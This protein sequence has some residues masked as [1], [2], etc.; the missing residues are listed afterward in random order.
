V[1]TADMPGGGRSQYVSRDGSRF[2]VMAVAQA[3]RRNL[4]VAINAV[5]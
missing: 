3:S 4:R 1:V 5:P 2:L